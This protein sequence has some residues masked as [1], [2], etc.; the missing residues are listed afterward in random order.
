MITAFEAAALRFDL[1]TF[2]LPLLASVS[3]TLRN[4]GCLKSRRSIFLRV[5]EPGRTPEFLLTR[6]RTVAVSFQFYS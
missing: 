3:T 2:F 6:E 5:L 1:A 4:P